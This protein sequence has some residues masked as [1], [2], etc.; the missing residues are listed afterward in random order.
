ME[1]YSNGLAVNL[2]MF[3]HQAAV[4]RR[5]KSERP[6]PREQ[7]PGAHGL[8]EVGENANVPREFLVLDSDFR[9][10]RAV[11]LAAEDACAAEQGVVAFD[12][13]AFDCGDVEGEAPD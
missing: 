4:N 1:R 8:T 5:T 6:S 10:I 13:P 3:I 7:V 2:I 11:E 9:A 12:F